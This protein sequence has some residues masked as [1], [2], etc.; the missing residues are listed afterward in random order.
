MA[1]HPTRS[2]VA[3]GEVNVNPDIHVWDPQTL[4]TLAVLTTS[5]KGGILHL[6]FSGAS[7][8]R[9]EKIISCGMDA[10]FSIQIF[11]WEQERSIAFR[12]TGK[13]PI[14]CIRA[15]PYNFNKFMT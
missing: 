11:Q 3:T 15:D 4:E 7:S 8:Q 13:L 10:T 6:T 12:N 2:L 5:H 9:T 14:F 1:L